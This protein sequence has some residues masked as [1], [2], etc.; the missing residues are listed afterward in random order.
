M[1]YN[2]LVNEVYWGYNPLILYWLPG[3]SK[4]R[5]AFLIKFLLRVRETDMVYI[6]ENERLEIGKSPE[7]QREM[8]WSKPAFF[9]SASIFRGLIWKHPKKLTSSLNNG[10]SKTTYCTSSFAKLCLVREIAGTLICFG[11]RSYCKTTSTSFASFYHSTDGKKF[12]SPN[13]MVCSIFDR[14]VYIYIS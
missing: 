5:Q 4:Y 6:L 11:V 2:L 12:C 1:G 7:I 8:I 10:G 13:D 9:G 14:D 3:T